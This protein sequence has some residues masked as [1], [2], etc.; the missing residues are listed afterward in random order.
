MSKCGVKYTNTPTEPQTNSTQGLKWWNI[1]QNKVC[2]IV[3]QK[4]K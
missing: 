1:V 4:V 2:I 3:Y